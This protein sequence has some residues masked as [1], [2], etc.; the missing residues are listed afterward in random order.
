MKRNSKISSHSTLLPGD[1]V[2]EN[3][4]IVAHILVNSGKPDN[5]VDVGAPIKVI[6]TLRSVLDS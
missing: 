5:V 1:T 3:S 4:I 6:K 2:G